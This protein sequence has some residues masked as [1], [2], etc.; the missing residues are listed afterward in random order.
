MSEIIISKLR[1]TGVFFCQL[2]QYSRYL[3]SCR[4]PQCKRCIHFLPGTDSGMK[5]KASNVQSQPAEAIHQIKPNIPNH[6]AASF[7]NPKQ[8]RVPPMAE[9]KIELVHTKGRCSRN[10]DPK[11]GTVQMGYELN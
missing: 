2:D 8:T 4:I 7:F 1:I 9:F 10:T 5:F 6:P 3:F 11:A